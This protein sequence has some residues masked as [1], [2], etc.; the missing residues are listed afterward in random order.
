MGGNLP[1]GAM[2]HGAGHGPGGVHV[3]SAAT[4]AA[5]VLLA[6]LVILLVGLSSFVGGF[7][8]GFSY[9]IKTAKLEAVGVSAPSAAKL[10]VA[11]AGAA[12]GLFQRA[13]GDDNEAISLVAELLKPAVWKGLE[14]QQ[15]RRGG[16]GG[17]GGDASSSS[18]E[19]APGHTPQTWLPSIEFHV[20]DNDG[21]RDN[22]N[23]NDGE[24][25]SEG[26]GDDDGVS[27]GG[28]G[29]VFFIPVSCAGLAD[30]TEPEREPS[31]SSS[32]SSSAGESESDESGAGSSDGGAAVGD[33][34]AAAVDDLVGSTSGARRMLMAMEIAGGVVKVGVGDTVGRGV[35]GF[36]RGVGGVGGVGGIGGFR[37]LRENAAVDGGENRMDRTDG[38]AGR[39]RRSLLFKATG[40]RHLRSF[41]NE[42]T[43][44]WPHWQNKGGSGGGGGGGGG[45]GN[46]GVVS[47]GGGGGGS[48]RQP[49]YACCTPS[50]GGGEGR[51][52][53]MCVRV[54]GLPHCGLDCQAQ[55]GTVN[56]ASHH[57]FG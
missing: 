35:G 44:R 14:R 57:K 29:R 42:V 23:D 17:G 3:T 40:Q 15:Q 25:D 24:N 18:L 47:G 12:G 26:D 8:G 34:A 39:R 4:A 51:E 28:L 55:K 19:T 53:S 41:L 5:K 21:D 27:V 11:E 6:I 22:K 32:S 54:R 46:K 16:G 2:H 33:M 7:V 37:G 20:H 52:T 38:E 9:G 43:M 10:L 45:Q 1:S 48:N 31:S 49:H 36:G 50:G 56:V 30:G 13:S